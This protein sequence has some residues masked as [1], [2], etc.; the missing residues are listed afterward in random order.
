MI[1]SIQSYNG[2][3]N[4]VSAPVN[5]IGGVLVVTPME[6]IAGKVISCVRRK[7]KPKSFT[8]RRDLAHM[9]LKFPEYKV[10]DGDVQQ[11]LVILGA[12]DETMEFWR[13]LVAEEL[14]AEDDDDEFS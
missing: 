2:Q 3:V 12:N 4:G 5:R 14:M 6:V 11:R 7:G 9:L 10:H 1:L 13:Q 8:D